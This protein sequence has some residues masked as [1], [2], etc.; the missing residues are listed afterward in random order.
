MIKRT[1]TA[2]LLATAATA[3]LAV[4]PANAGDFAGGYL[5]AQLGYSYGDFNL[6]NAVGT[7]T[8]FDSDSVIGGI[9][10]GYLWS[11]GN[12]WYVGPEFQ[13]DWANIT[14]TDSTNGQTAKFDKI[15]RLNLVGGYEMGNGMLYGT[16]GYA[17]T[18]LSGVGDFFDGSSNGY[19]IGFGYDWWVD[20]N[21][22]VG[23]EYLYQKFD[24]IGSGGGDVG[25][26]AIY[27]RTA[28]R[29]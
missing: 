3:A 11:V 20:D 6:D 18:D 17:Y 8:D 10:A 5:G 29:F 25:V 23:G 7:I 22:T 19:A 1:S 4:A 24:S 21:W 14:I 27:L 2:L 15:A 12:G 9:S 26:S 13:Y 28:Y 16:L